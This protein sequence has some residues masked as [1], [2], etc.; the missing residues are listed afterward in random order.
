MC[1]KLQK[2][3]EGQ[4]HRDLRQRVLRVSNRSYGPFLNVTPPLTSDQYC[5]QFIISKEGFCHTLLVTGICVS[6]VCAG[7][8]GAFLIRLVFVWT[9]TVITPLPVQVKGFH[10]GFPYCRESTY[11]THWY[12]QVCLI[13]GKIHVVNN[14]LI[15]NYL[16]YKWCYSAAGNM[17]P[18]P[19][20]HPSRYNQ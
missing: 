15:K 17:Y 12:S 13:S 8:P 9:H 10:S 2:N 18:K 7:V 5:M 16:V 3:T 6:H 19:R 20:S 1:K 14:I 11:R 4:L